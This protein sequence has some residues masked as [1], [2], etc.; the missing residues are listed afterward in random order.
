MIVHRRYPRPLAALVS[1]SRDG[2]MLAAI[3]A[4]FGV[5]VVRGS[6]SRRGP[7]ALLE[8]TSRAELGF[9]VAVTPDGPRG[10]RYIVQMGVIALAQLTGSPIIPVT[11]ETYPKI[12]LKSWDRF[13][14][15]LPFSVCRI[16]LHEPLV[17]PRDLSS[18]GREKFR[19]QLQS[20]LLS[21]GR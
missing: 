8:L 15:P 19:S 6:T 11:S 10:P 13:Q 7:Q 16:T 17:V 4:A 9:D 20:Q 1:A 14:V 3:L 5:D 12:C 21:T 2:A 18:D